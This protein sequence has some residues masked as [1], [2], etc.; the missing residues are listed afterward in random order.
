MIMR[1]MI[2]FGK[3]KSGA[4]STILNLAEFHAKSSDSNPPTKIR[5]AALF[6][7][8]LLL[9][10]SLTL[11]RMEN[12]QKELKQLDASVWKSIYFLEQKISQIGLQLEEIIKLIFRPIEAHLNAPKSRFIGERWAA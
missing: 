8:L 3:R 10:K 12:R 1:Q 5:R 9:F 7:R 4:L 11:W 2:L 6:L